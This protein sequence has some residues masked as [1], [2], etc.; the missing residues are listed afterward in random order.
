M[1]VGH[2][3]FNTFFFCYKYLYTNLNVSIEQK[4]LK[5]YDKMDHTFLIYFGTSL[6]MFLFSGIF[7]RLLNTD[8]NLKISILKKNSLY[9]LNKS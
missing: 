4:N 9:F 2:F 1:F 5:R 3:Y 7:H 6:A 8:Q